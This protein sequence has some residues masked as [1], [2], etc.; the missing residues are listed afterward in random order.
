MQKI[1]LKGL[2]RLLGIT[3]GV[4]CVI[5]HINGAETGWIDWSFAKTIGLIFMEGLVVF[6]LGL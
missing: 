5:I 3:L 6:L 4:F 2:V 1:M